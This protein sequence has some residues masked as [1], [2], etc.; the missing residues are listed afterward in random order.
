MTDTLGV[1]RIR[2]GFFALC[3]ALLLACGMSLPAYAAATAATV[4]LSEKGSIT[5]TLEATDSTHPTDGELSLYQVA[6]LELINGNMT[7]VYTS[8]F[9]GC[10]ASL[11]D[12]TVASLA[13]ELDTFVKE[14]GLEA[15]STSTISSEGTVSFSDLSVGLYLV[16]QTTQ[17]SGYS[18]ID[19]F[20]VSIPLDV[21]DT[22]VYDVDAS[23]KIEPATP[24]SDNPDN[25]G[26]DNPGGDNPDTPGSTTPGGTTGSGGTTPGTGSTDGTSGTGT[27]GTGT[28]GTSGTGTTSPTA[29]S[30]LPQTGQLNWPIPVLCVVGALCVVVGIVINRS[31]HKKDTHAA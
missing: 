18:L 23:P 4:D 1:R 17:S 3:V 10:T 19:S 13:S 6:D 27:P 20:L 7:Y 15:I 16:A 22:W 28:G 5:A 31:T 12:V 25:P 21:D 8:A 24:D 26:G 14:H 29:A 11:D 2:T 30:T 9:E